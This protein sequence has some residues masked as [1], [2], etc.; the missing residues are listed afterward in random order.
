MSAEPPAESI[1][2]PFG[3]KTL[4]FVATPDELDELG[5]AA[6]DLGLPFDAIERDSGT[7]FNLGQVGTGTVYARQTS[8]GALGFEGSAARAIYCSYETSASRIVYVG[9]A[10]GIDRELQKHGDVL[11]S[12][13]L[14]PYDLRDVRSD[15]GL[16][17]YDYGRVHAFPAAEGLLLR[18]PLI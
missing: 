17:K 5:A 8:M 18:H 1:S 10:F 7:Y 2:P 3:C 6:K 4:L 9:M 12:S 11:V 15:A 14:L 16:P 13:S